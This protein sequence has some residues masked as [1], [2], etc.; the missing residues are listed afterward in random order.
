M[1]SAFKRL[2]FGVKFQSLRADLSI[3]TV[4]STLFSFLGRGFVLS[5]GG[6]PAR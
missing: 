6:L 1:S 5:R 2:D 4:G 3:A